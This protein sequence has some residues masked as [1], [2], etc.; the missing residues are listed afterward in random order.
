M[1]GQEYRDSVRK[2]LQRWNKIAGL[3]PDTGVKMGQNLF[4]RLVFSAA[5]NAERVAQPR[6]RKR[7]IAS[8]R[9]VGKAG[10]APQV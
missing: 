2:F 10:V 8:R 9:G 6:Q 4:V 3:Q 5:G 7:G 1:G